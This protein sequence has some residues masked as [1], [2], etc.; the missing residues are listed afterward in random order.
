MAKANFDG[1]LADSIMVATSTIS[2]A[3]MV[4]CAGLM[5]AFIAVNGREEFKMVSEL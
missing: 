4:K 2:S 3:D 5:V 1:R